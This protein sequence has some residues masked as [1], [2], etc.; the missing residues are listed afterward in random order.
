MANGRE[1][2]W[3]D[4]AREQYGWGVPSWIARLSPSVREYWSTYVDPTRKWQKEAKPS[5]WGYPELSKREYLDRVEL[6]LANQVARGDISED[7]A[8]AGYQGAADKL[9]WE[10]IHPNLPY[11]SYVVEPS[12]AQF[13]YEQRL[14][15]QEAEAKESARMGATRYGEFLHQAAQAR[16]RERWA[17]GATPVIEEETTPP[18]RAAQVC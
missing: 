16:G 11:Y 1:K 7:E 10:G 4:W 2:A 18:W 8:E 13:E 3:Q 12:M 15:E 17:E 5:K 14:G 9:T 6:Y